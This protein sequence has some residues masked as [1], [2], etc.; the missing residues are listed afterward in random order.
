[1]N[2]SVPMSRR[3][4]RRLTERLYASALYRP[5]FR[6]AGAARVSV[7]PTDPWPG[8]PH[9]ADHLFQGR[10]RFAG[11]DV[12]AGA[13]S[14]FDLPP[15]SDA[16]LEELNGFS[17][18]RHFHA[19]GGPAAIRHARALV[20]AWVDRYGRF[21][22]HAWAPELL[23]RRL[24]AWL[25]HARFLLA[26]TDPA[27]QDGFLRSINVQA[28]HLERCAHLANTAEAR[29]TVA[30]GLCFVGLALGANERR[31]GRA[32]AWLKREIEIQILGDGGHVA[33]NPSRHMAVLRD[34]VALRG[35]GEAAAMPVPAAVPAAIERMA[36]MLRFFRHGD[37]K[38]AVFHGGEEESA[39]AIDLTL[40]RAEAPG[41]APASAP[42]SRFERLS[43]RR[44]LLLFDGG[45]PADDGLAGLLAFEFSSAGER[46]VVNCGTS[47]HARPAWRRALA[48]TAAHSTLTLADTNAID[49]EPPGAV[50]ALP[51]VE[52][53][54]TDGSIWLDAS[55]EGYRRR[56]GAI[57]RRR[58]YL[59]ASG[60]DVRGEDS[61]LATGARAGQGAPLA[62][63][64]HLHPDVSVSLAQSGTAALLKTARGQGWRFIAQG[65][66]IDIEDSVYFGE[67]GERRA[68]RQI[69]VNATFS[70]P[71]TRVKW[72]LVRAGA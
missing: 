52:R 21:D 58:L 5:A 53:Q 36:P 3:L 12:H 26:K 8:D 16:W 10:Y 64:F 15:P 40:G 42:E 19:A 22:G 46:L 31:R 11:E 28:R 67:R 14:P 29:L 32:E 37:G 68:S 66:R 48:A 24:M 41:R 72:A 2:A 35:L 30:I 70:G 9:L 25:G 69:A 17:W 71:D 38:L 6:S 43:A 59:D 61:L 47:R 18:L 44:S 60:D 20:G 23:A 34:L 54:E 50:F 45:F 63:R 39:A 51:R 13:Q 49:V 62:V 4:T 65:G 56:F 7:F 55:H 1:M 33:R 27:W 57:H